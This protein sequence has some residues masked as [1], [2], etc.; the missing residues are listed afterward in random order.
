MAAPE[1][2]PDM[3]QSAPTNLVAYEMGF[4][5]QMLACLPCM[6]CIPEIHPIMFVKLSDQK[7]LL[8]RTGCLS[9]VFEDDKG[10]VQA[11]ATSAGCSEW[12]YGAYTITDANNQPVCHTS[13]SDGCCKPTEIVVTFEDK[14]ELKLSMSASGTKVKGEDGAGTSIA[15]I[16]KA[17][18][19]GLEGQLTTAYPFPV[20]AL[21]LFSFAT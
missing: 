1:S 7:G 4:E 11:S 15:E 21:L 8:R 10:A 13:R 20:L 19:M 2:Q 17:G 16:Q 3:S 18:H 5:N 12:C 14:T 9:M 6:I